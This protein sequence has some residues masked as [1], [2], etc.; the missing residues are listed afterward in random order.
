[1]SIQEVSFV[2]RFFVSMITNCSRTQ[3]CKYINKSAMEISSSSITNGW[4]D[5]DLT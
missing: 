2:L 3:L 1:M 5:L 4:N